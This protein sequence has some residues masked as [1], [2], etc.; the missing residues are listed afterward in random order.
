MLKIFQFLVIMLITISSAAQNSATTNEELIKDLIIDSFREIFSENRKEKIPRYYTNEFLLLEDEEVWD[1][2]IIR[3][4]M[5]KT[6]KMDRLPERINS[7]DFMK[8]EISGDMAWTAYHNK[9]VFKLD[10]EVVGEMNWLE[11]ATAILTKDGW[12]L[13]MLH[14]TVVEE[15]KKAKN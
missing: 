1:L 3:S 14:S 13:Q 5:E 2:V 9:A 7:F 8:V 4:Y 12:R 10:G 11:S 6:A 15:E